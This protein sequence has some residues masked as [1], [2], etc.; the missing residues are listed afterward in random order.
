LAKL[1]ILETALGLYQ[2]PQLVEICEIS[3]TLV[4]FMKNHIQVK[5][6]RK[7][8]ITSPK[9]THKKM[10]IWQKPQKTTK[11]KKIEKKKTTKKIKVMN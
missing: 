4:E 10:S 1:K 2:N 5:N 11:S 9:S 7:T 6:R 3:K 8:S